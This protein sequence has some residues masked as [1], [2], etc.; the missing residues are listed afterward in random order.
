M[1]ALMP[2][3]GSREDPRAIFALDASRRGRTIGL[4]LCRSVT[5]TGLAGVCAKRRTLT[6]Q[7]TPGDGRYGPRMT[8]QERCKHRD[9]MAVRVG[10]R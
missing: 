2:A 7:A 6:V 8:V 10:R 3:V 9:D 1:V 5:L 4:R